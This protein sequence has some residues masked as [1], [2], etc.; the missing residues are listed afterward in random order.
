[1]KNSVQTMVVLALAMSLCACISVT[2]TGSEKSKQVADM[3]Q[4]AVTTCGQGNV[5]KVSTSSFT[6]KGKQ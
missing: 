3:A 2:E 1:M 6:C 4:Q 5:D